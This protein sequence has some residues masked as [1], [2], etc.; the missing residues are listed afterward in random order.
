[1]SD[2]LM[3][4]GGR[5]DIFLYCNATSERKKYALVSGAGPYVTSTGKWIKYRFVDRGLA[6]PQ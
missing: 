5:A 1:M 4:A 6:I 3:F 2:L